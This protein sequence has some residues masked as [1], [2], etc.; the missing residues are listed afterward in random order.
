M[1]L[2]IGPEIVAQLPLQSDLVKLE[3]KGHAVGPAGDPL[4]YHLADLREVG[5]RPEARHLRRWR[6]GAAQAACIWRAWPVTCAAATLSCELEA[7]FHAEQ[8]RNGV[9]K[10]GVVQGHERVEQQKDVPPGVHLDPDR[11]VHK[12]VTGELA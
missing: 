8:R 11:R 12:A 2:S 4:R 9:A 6:H 3:R 10:A 7:H 1:T 5:A